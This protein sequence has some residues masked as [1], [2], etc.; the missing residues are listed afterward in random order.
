MQRFTLVCWEHNYITKE[1][2]YPGDEYGDDYDNVELEYR[3]E[4][5]RHQSAD[6]AKIYERR[7]VAG[8]STGLRV[9]RIWNS[10]RSRKGVLDHES[11]SALV[12]CWMHLAN[13]KIVVCASEHVDQLCKTWKS[14]YATISRTCL[15]GFNDPWK[16]RV[17]FAHRL[18]CTPMIELY[19]LKGTFIF[20][21]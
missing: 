3:L 18:K 9:V 19:F 2:K 7:R 10:N 12:L 15:Y 1:E 8:C 13:I 6:S 20:Y 5:V 11:G 17:P 21:S 14:G 4:E 16:K